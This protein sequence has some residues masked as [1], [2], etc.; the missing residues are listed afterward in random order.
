MTNPDPFRYSK[1]SREIIGIGQSW[2]DPELEKP[3][4]QREE[5]LSHQSVIA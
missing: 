3:S 4:K 1:T 2:W 5:K